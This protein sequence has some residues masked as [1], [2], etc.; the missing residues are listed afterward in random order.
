MAKLSQQHFHPSLACGCCGRI[1]LPLLATTRRK[2][3]KNIEHP[4]RKKEKAKKAG[5]PPFYFSFLYP[6][7]FS[8]LIKLG[9]VP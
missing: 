2:N 4:Q 9:D 1:P 3:E 5:S 6:N 8:Y 7:M